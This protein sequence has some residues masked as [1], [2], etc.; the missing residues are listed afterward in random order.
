MVSF[1]DYEFQVFFFISDIPVGKIDLEYI[2]VQYKTTVEVYT[3]LVE[4]DLM[5]PT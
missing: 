4:K 2:I 1:I 5:S 3:I